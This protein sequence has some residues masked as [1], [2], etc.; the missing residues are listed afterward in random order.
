MN[1]KVIAASAAVA[2]ATLGGVVL[3]APANAT[4]GGGQKDKCYVAGEPRTE[5]TW[6]EY[7]NVQTSP[8]SPESFTVNGDFSQSSTDGS[9]SWSGAADGLHIATTET[10]H[11]KVAGYLNISAPVSLYSLTDFDLGWTGT[12]TPPGGQILVDLDNDGTFTGYMVIEDAY[13][14]EWWLSA[15][16]A[17][18]IDLTAGPVTA[19]GGG[20]VD[21]ATP[22]EFQ[23]VYPDAKA[24][25]VGFSFGS[26]VTGSGVISGITAGGV[27]YSFV[28]TVPATEPTYEWQ[29]NGVTGQGTEVPAD[30]E[31][32]HYVRGEDVS[33]PT[34]DKVACDLAP[35]VEYGEWI[36]TLGDCE[37]K[38]D[39]SERT[40][41]TTPWVKEKV[42]YKKY[43]LTAGETVIGE[44][45]RTAI[46]WTEEQIAEECPTVTP[47]PNPTSNPTPVPA[48]ATLPRTGGGDVSPLVPLAAGLTAALGVTL[49]TLAVYRRRHSA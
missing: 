35:V 29:A 47:S 48:A 46:A 44:P 27:N 4:Y 42:G 23:A 43:V 18:D 45:E 30:T 31:S 1:K 37:T 36:T 15:N 22:A 26:G 13:A 17:N 9:A 39:V 12:A 2:L 24:Y 33:I 3:A 8:G 6:A 20:G 41:S 38:A 16:W 25:Q 32:V 19:V 7:T 14:G 11:R 21:W 28:T 10:G 40:V 5:V 34:W 49:V